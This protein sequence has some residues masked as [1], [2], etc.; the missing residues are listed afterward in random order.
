[1]AKPTIL[2]E[3]GTG[4][5]MYP[6][7]LASLVKTADGGNVDE[8]L[9]KAK[10]ALFVDMWNEV[11][12]VG[13]T[14]YGKYDPTNAPDPNKP[15]ML[16]KLWFSYSEAMHIYTISHSEY[17]VAP[18]KIYGG[19][20]YGD[21]PLAYLPLRIN[22]HSGESCGGIFDGNSKMKACCV[23]GSTGSYGSSD[24]INAFNNCI[25]LEVIYGGVRPL[26]T[27][28]HMNQCFKG[29]AALKEVTIPLGYGKINVS[30]ED[31]PLISLL[32]L[33]NSISESTY[34]ENANTLTVHPDV[35]AKITGDTS[36][37]A[38]AALT[39]EELAQWQQLLT[40]AAAKNITFA[41]T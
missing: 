19:V 12:K 15:F 39:P 4:E 30:L 20:T 10:F 22:S 24:W 40:D 9:E 18:K 33:Q 21:L 27:S 17:V 28:A 7:T 32:S 3:R 34:V 35:Y 5:E 41:T 2:K 26:Y 38:A 31:S 23:I 13:N 8:G 1:M 36:N 16:Y 14:V 25:A 29:C 37:E 11:C 6:H